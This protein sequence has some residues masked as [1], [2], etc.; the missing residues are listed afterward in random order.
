MLWYC[1]PP[2]KSSVFCLASNMSLSATT[3]QR[4][5][6]R[7]DVCHIARKPAHDLGWKPFFLYARSS[8]SQSRGRSLSNHAIP[9]HPHCHVHVRANRLLSWCFSRNL[10]FRESQIW[11][12]F[13]LDCFGSHI[14]SC[15]TPSIF[16]PLPPKSQILF[17]NLNWWKP[18][19]PTPLCFTPLTLH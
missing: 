3:S 12:I 2:L 13:Q 6:W 8:L 16:P 11:C 10:L 1:E 14:L 7:N 17:L 18:H 4:L 9:P 19:Y 15:M 5:E